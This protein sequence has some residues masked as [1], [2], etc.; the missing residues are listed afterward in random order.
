MFVEERLTQGH[1]VSIISSQPHDN[2]MTLLSVNAEN[3]VGAD[4]SA[5]TMCN[6]SD[7]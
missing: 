3:C 2:I 7:V 1:E 4:A 5:H 6:Y